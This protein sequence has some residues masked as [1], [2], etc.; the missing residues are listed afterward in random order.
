[1]KT[2]MSFAERDITE[3]LFAEYGAE[4]L[5]VIIKMAERARVEAEAGSIDRYRWQV[6]RN[7]L[8]NAS[9]QIRDAEVRVEKWIEESMGE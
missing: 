4:M 3:T 5:E 1:M 9:T 7:T 6:V 2:E 8:A